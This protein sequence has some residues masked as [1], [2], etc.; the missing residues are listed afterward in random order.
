MAWRGPLKPV[1]NPAPDQLKG[2][3][4]TPAM[5]KN[6]NRAYQKR[7]DTDDVKNFSVS[8][9]DIDTTI[10][11][12]LNDVIN[13]QV[14]DNGAL[15]KVP[16]NYSSPERWKAI[17]KD[18]FMRDKNGKIQCPV[19]AFNRANMQRNDT[20]ITF[21][22]YLSY[23][24]IRKF[25]QKNQY[26]RFSIMSGFSPVREI[27]DITMPDHV[28][29]NYDFI[30]WTDYIEQQNSIIENLNFATEDYWGDK[31]RF[32]FRTSISDYQFP[33]EISA[34]GDRIVK[35][36]FSMMVYAYLLP[37]TFENRKS[38][39][40][41]AFTPRKVV[42][43]VEAV[44]KSRRIKLPDK[45]SIGSSNTKVNQ[46]TQPPIPA[47]GAGGV[48]NSSNGEFTSIDIKNGPV[49]SQIRTAQMA[50]I[51]SDMVL[52][53]I[54]ASSANS[55][56]WLVTIGDGINFYTSQIIANWNAGGNSVNFSEFGSNSIGT[57]TATLSVISSNGNI[58]LHV[59]PSSGIWNAKSIRTSL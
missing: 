4:Q 52:D 13:L 35:A 55:A 32:K 17:R 56:Q 12:Y 27:Y 30:V 43:D 21:N 2:L 50:G 51:S 54:P 22:R 14:M 46:V 5:I 48:T 38:T 25:S 41:K 36:T 57:V 16:V 19:L 44:S 37:E 34:D 40:Q 1:T 29:I 7:R 3:I 31:V 23:P 26:D 42:F 45:L 15:V 24:T 39:T 20:L 33:T 9:L 49:D 6:D 47:T 58:E 18:G 11:N 53:S 59:I 28:I 8:L 10:T